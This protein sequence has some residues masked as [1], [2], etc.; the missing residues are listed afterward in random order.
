MDNKL[1]NRIKKLWFHPDV[2]KA[3]RDHL[4]SNKHSPR[5]KFIF[6][7]MIMFAGV[8]IVKGSTVIDSVA[9]HFFADVLGYLLHGVGAVPVIKSIEEGGAL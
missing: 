2:P 7:T 8:G 9:I 3:V 4:L 1:T 6:G 5:H